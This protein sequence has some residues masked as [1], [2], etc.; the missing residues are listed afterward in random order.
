MDWFNQNANAIN[1]A[2][3]IILAVLTSIYV[4]LTRRMVKE[5]AK[6]REPSVNVDFELPDSMLLLVVSN[7]GQSVARDVRFRVKKDVQWL[8]PAPK[9]NGLSEMSVLRK[10]ISYLPPGRTL[11]YHAGVVH[12]L[13]EKEED[14]LFSLE[15]T[16]ESDFG[17]IQREIIIDMRQFSGVL[18]ASFQS[19]LRKI[20][21]SLEKIENAIRSRRESPLGLITKK[22]CPMCSENIPS[23]ARKC[24]RCGEML[25]DSSGLSSA[26]A[27][28]APKEGAQ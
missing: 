15:L 26:R 25:S 17:T 3:T 20:S 13:R 1:A 10:G 9:Q 27:D 21:E 24:S 6:S 4:Y 8:S 22:Q 18:F 14:N 2:A 28:G 5:M 11:K 12:D 19:P 16:Y 23:A 7:L